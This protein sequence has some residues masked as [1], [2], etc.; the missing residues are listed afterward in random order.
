MTA[1]PAPSRREWSKQDAPASVGEMAVQVRPSRSIPK[2]LLVEPAAPSVVR[3]L[4]ETQHYLH[5]MPPAPRLCF[6]VHLDGILSGALVFTSGAR[7]GHRLLAAAEPHQV[8]TLARLWLADELPRNSESRVLGVV[9]RH[10]RRTTDWKLLLTYADPS[11]GHV[12]TIYQA[13]G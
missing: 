8:A 9:L 13:A 10:L 11:A 5:S 3:S 12:G 4:I 7:H 1:E 6:G 2:T